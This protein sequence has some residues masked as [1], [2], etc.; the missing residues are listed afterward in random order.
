[1]KVMLSAVQ[2]GLI[3]GGL[4]EMIIDNLSSAVNPDNAKLGN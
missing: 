2:I 1:M 3:N 4:V